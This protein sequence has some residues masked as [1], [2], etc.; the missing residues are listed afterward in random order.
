VIDQAFADAMQIGAGDHFSAQP[1]GYAS[2]GEQMHFVVLAVVTNIPTLY[3]DPQIENGGA[4]GLLVDYQT[5]A[6]VYHQDTRDTSPTPGTIWLRTLDDGSS[7]ASVRSALGSGKLAVDQLQDRRQLISK[8]Q[9]NP[10]VVD[11][12]GTL[13]IGAATALVLALLGVLIA[14]WLSARTRLTSF[15]LLRA[16]GTEPRQLT[17]VLLFEQGI[18]YSLSIALGVVI[19]VVLSILVLP[20]LVIANGIADPST[21]DPSK[22]NVPPVHA[23][24]PLPLLGLALGILIAICLLSIV[25]MTSVVARASIGQTLR[26]N[27]D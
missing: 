10:L 15:A 12:F 13:D 2:S 18:V 6:D 5:F 23:V 22:L 1:T 7:L 8:T 3:D 9:S 17:S 11:L 20:V 24:Y 16:I 27:E 14:S 4:G 19:G 21:F 26:L 25:L